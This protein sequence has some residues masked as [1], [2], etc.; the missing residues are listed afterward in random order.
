MNKNAE[1]DFRA[2]ILD[3]FLI[4][5]HKHL[6]E[7]VP[8]HREFLEKD[9]IFYGHLAVWVQSH[10]D[11]RNHKELFVTFLL[12]SPLP[13]HKEAGFVLIQKF[14]PYGVNRI[15]SQIRENLKKNISRIG[16]KVV[17][18][19]LEQREK[20]I[21]WFDGAVLRQ[22]KALKSLYARLHI[23]ILS[24]GMLEYSLRSSIKR[25]PR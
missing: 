18:Y 20:D 14:P 7:I 12:T 8:I 15:I 21:N 6:E 11:I 24:T 13:Q 10:I 17:K 4:S 5:T 1:Q 23:K 9:P 22:R 2:R 16:K 19:Y 25:L 3:S